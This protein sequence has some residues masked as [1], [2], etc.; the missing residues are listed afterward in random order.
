MQASQHGTAPMLLEPALAHARDVGRST[1]AGMV[2]HPSPGHHSGTL[3]NAIL[4]HCGLSTVT[5]AGGASAAPAS[6]DGLRALQR[7]DASLAGSPADGDEPNGAKAMAVARKPAQPATVLAC[8]PATGARGGG[9]AGSSSSSQLAA[10]A[11]T[12][13]VHD[14]IRGLTLAMQQ[15]ETGG[16]ET[17]S[18]MDDDDEDGGPIVLQAA[19]GQG[20]V[21]R[22][23][24]VH[25]L[26][27]GAQRAL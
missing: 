5:A 4:H 15:C 14:R 20:V 7:S 24:I 8:A 2:V 16:H 27:K 22:P 23:G 3:V 13:G 11:A 9:R 25:R 18:E 19:P 6:L 10:A 1:G 12:V 26:D 17:A 21:L